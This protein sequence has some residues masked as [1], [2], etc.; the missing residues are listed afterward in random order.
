MPS[1]AKFMEN[2]CPQNIKITTVGIYRTH[3]I[4]TTYKKR[5]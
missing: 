3:L 5:K 1:A 2:V 4:S